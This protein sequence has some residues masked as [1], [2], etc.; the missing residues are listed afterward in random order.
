MVRHEQTGHD[1]AVQN[2]TF[3]DFGDIGIRFHAVPDAFGIDHDAGSL[4]AMIETAC[5]VRAD[6]VLQVQA[7]GFR[8]KAGVQSF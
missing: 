4:G 8:L 6:D 7:L 2:V 5:L 3:H 1:F